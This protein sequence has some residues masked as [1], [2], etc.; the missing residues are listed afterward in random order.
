[1][2]V[3]IFLFDFIYA[4]ICLIFRTSKA[5]STPT[6]EWPS[7]ASRGAAWA[8]LTIGIVL[9]VSIIYFGIAATIESSK[10]RGEY[11]T[12]NGVPITRAD[13]EECGGKIPEGCAGGASVIINK[14]E[15]IRRQGG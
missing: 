13:F 10:P 4:A 12:I 7:N 5:L 8:G 14:Y 2:F 3:F 9:L 1:M 11:G 15:S 6:A